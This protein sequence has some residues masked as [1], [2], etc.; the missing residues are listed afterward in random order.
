M[1]I[2]DPLWTVE[3]LARYLKRSRRWIF[4]HL[5]YAPDRRGSIP[6]VRL[7]GSRSPRFVPTIISA[8]VR[9]GCPPVD[10]LD[11]GEE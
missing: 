7:A 8:W 9:Q 10:E 2:I 3:D 11:L 4:T 6:H 1:N 5:G